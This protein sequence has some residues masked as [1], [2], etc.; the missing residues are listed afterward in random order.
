MVVLVRLNTLSCVV[1]FDVVIDLHL[2]KYASIDW[3]RVNAHLDALKVTLAFCQFEPGMLTNL[4]DSVSLLRIRVQNAVE[5]V[6]GFV[7]D[8]IWRLEVS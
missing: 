6:L 4:F 8:V 1:L 5:E 2:V 7:G 3:Y